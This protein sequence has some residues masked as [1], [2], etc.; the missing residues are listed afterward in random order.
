MSV[1]CPLT[2]APSALLTPLAPFAPVDRLLRWGDSPSPVLADGAQRVGPGQAPAQH[3][4]LDIHG[5]ASP[6]REEVERFI[7][8]V[9]RDRFGADVQAFAP[10]L[11]CRR[12]PDGAPWAAA[13]YR[14]AESGALFLE[15]YLDA[16]VEQALATGRGEIVEVGHLAASRAGEGRRLILQLGLLLARSGFQWAVSTMTEELRHLFQRLG[17]AQR[18]LGVADPLRL[19]ANA[20]RWGCY[21]EHH[22]V[23]LASAIGTAPQARAACE[24]RS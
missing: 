18:A 13:G 19:G 10:V 2:I 14:P 12:S 4:A 17:V 8:G 20:A 22:P 9:Y 6:G 16:P 5:P 21:Y 3:D 11:V 1:L 7:A 15:R 24:V 23:V